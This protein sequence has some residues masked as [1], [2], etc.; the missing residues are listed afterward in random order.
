MKKSIK[1]TTNDPKNE[2]IALKLLGKVK[3]FVTIHPS[4]VFLRGKVGDSISQTVSIIPGE[5]ESFKILQA[6]ALKGVGYKFALKDAE[7]EGRAAYELVVENTRDIPGRY[8]DKIFLITD[9]T[10]QAPINVIVSGYLENP[11]PPEVEKPEPAAE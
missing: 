5:G 7:I 11:P 1:V 9:R 6:N 3:R 4:K 8:F 10:D 2:R